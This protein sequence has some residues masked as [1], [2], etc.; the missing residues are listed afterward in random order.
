MPRSIAVEK[1]GCVA[2]GGAA[3]AAAAADAG[4]AGEEVELNGDIG[5]AAAVDPWSAGITHL[6]PSLR[7][8]KC[9]NIKEL[10]LKILEFYRPGPET[11]TSKGLQD[12]HQPALPHA[13][14]QVTNLMNFFFGKNAMTMEVLADS[15][16]VSVRQRRHRFGTSFTHPSALYYP[17][18]RRDIRL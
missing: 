12:M 9:H 8:F 18:R 2:P 16:S 10:K 3:G 6:L 11:V 7:I 1:G 14:D 5:V 4:G 15:T 17:A 13:A